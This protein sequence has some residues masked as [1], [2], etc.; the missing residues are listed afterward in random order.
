[1][2]ELTLEQKKANLKKEYEQGLE[3]ALARLEK[4]EAADNEKANVITNINKEFDTFSKA[5]ATNSKNVR[6]LISKFKEEYLTDFFTNFGDART[7]TLKRQEKELKALE[8]QHKQ[9]KDNISIYYHLP[10]DLDNKPKDQV[11]SVE[12][13]ITKSLA[14]RSQGTNG[15]PDY[16]VLIIDGKAKAIIKQDGSTMLSS[17][18]VPYTTSGNMRKNAILKSVVFIKEANKDITKIPAENTIGLDDL[19][20]ENKASVKE[21]IAK[22]K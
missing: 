17:I 8:K 7:Q 16:R 1:M 9:E 19:S 14:K 10:F 5:I 22:N 4:T 13:R 15:I 6:D 20:D 21:W 3:Q 12:E 11:L 18:N 2:A